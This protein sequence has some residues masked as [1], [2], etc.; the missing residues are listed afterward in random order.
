MS[1]IS[2]IEWTERTWNPLEGRERSRNSRWGSDYPGGVNI[3]TIEV[4]NS[5][6]HIVRT[7]RALGPAV[8]V[9]PDQAVNKLRIYGI[10]V[11]A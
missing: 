5:E 11:E 2:S 10:R 8:V 9:V 4:K 6:W 1:A 7:A 3:D